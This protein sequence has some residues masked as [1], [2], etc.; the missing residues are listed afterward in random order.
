MMGISATPPRQREP[1]LPHTQCAGDWWVFLSSRPWY[2]R[3]WLP[4]SL[5]AERDCDRDVEHSLL[6]LPERSHSRRLRSLRSCNVTRFS[7]AGAGCVPLEGTGLGVAAH[8]WCPCRLSWTITAITRAGPMA[9]VG[10]MLGWTAGSFLSLSIVFALQPA[11]WGFR[12]CCA[13]VMAICT[14]SLSV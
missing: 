14:R 10:S 11:R 7:G 8:V 1:H 6:E 3:R 4:R 9:C 2:S 12:A 13:P 5:L